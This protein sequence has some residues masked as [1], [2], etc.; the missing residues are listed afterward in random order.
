MAFGSDTH[1]SAPRLDLPD[2][3]SYAVDAAALLRA[4]SGSQG[5]FPSS[6]GSAG[7]AS[8]CPS[9]PAGAILG[10]VLGPESELLA[11][12]VLFCLRAALGVRRAGDPGYEV[13]A[14]EV[15]CG[16]CG[17][18]LGLSVVQLGRLHAGTTTGCISNWRELQ[19][20]GTCFL[21]KRYLRLRRPDGGEEHLGRPVPSA[22]LAPYRCT[23]ARSQLRRPGQCGALL[24]AAGDVLS[25]QHRW[26]AGG[27]PERAFYINAFAPGAVDVRNEREELLCQGAMRVA[28][29]YC[30]TCGAR[31]GWRFCADLS[32]GLE[33]CN[34]VGR[35]GVVRSSIQKGSAVGSP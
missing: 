21:G 20:L 6:G 29:V 1:R 2:S 24:F 32:P 22:S 9:G 13:R 5:C 4:S 33:N 26:D 8:G 35:Y 30:A 18:H 7:S 3:D 11:A 28:D 12:P 16:G 23:A 15:L 10:A 14:R 25:R 31:I 27:G 19:L 17:L 34:Q